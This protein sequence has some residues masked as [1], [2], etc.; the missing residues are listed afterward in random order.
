MPTIEPVKFPSDHFPPK[1]PV[2]KASDIRL[3][4]GGAVTPWSRW[5]YHMKPPLLLMRCD[6]RNHVTTLYSAGGTMQEWHDPL[7]ALRW[8][9]QFRVE[10]AAAGPPFKGG[11]V[12]YFSYDFGRVFEKI[13]TIAQDDLFLPLFQ[14]TYHDDLWALD[15][16]SN[17]NYRISTPRWADPVPIRFRDTLGIG[18]DQSRL[19]S[20]FRRSEYQKAVERCIEYIR[21]GD[22]FQINLSQRFS[23]PLR[24]PPHQIYL[25]LHRKSPGWFGAYLG[26]GN[27]AIVSNSPELFLRVT[28]DPQT[29]QRKVITR[30]IKGTRP[31]QPG[32]EDTLRKSEKDAAELNMIIDLE[33]NDLGR[34]CETG[35]VQVTEPRSIEAHP[36]VYH[37]VA[38]VEGTLREE[39]G[40]VD[41]LRATFP[42]GSI[43]GA[44]K[45]RA[46]E[47]ID[48]IEPFRRGP[49][50]GA[51]GFISVDGH[52]ELNISIRTM[53]FTQGKVH[54]SV[55]G[56]IVADSNP[57][58]EY[59]ETLV[60][61]QA[62]CEAVG[63]PADDLKMLR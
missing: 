4:S 10:P 31:L 39:V 62:M 3:E 27:H 52:I 55:G 13:P 1:T 5:T 42:G 12:G 37:G 7:E 20:T 41:L 57:S 50:C 11:W 38:T 14:F 48:E 56:G 36:T 2:E 18:Q 28:P 53:V 47:I 15:R 54:L 51:T 33:R 59:D 22:V 34:V 21:A 16:Q 29:G 23:A 44:P 8:L 45:I 30:P 58:D 61:A 24:E 49:Y 35:S 9:E 19:I 17:E 46:M 63:I 43:T 6:A 32:M 40:L 25:R 26:L 60:K